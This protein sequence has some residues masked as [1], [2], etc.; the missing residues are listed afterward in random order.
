M[1]KYFVPH[2]KTSRC[3]KQDAT[4]LAVQLKCITAGFTNFCLKNVSTCIFF[5]INSLKESANKYHVMESVGIAVDV[6]F[7]VQLNSMIF[8][9]EL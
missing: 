3:I 1:T 9:K 8:E 2:G 7:S 6:F 4:F 5:K